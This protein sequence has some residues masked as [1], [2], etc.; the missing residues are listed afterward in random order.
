[1]PS[2]EEEI[3]TYATYPANPGSDLFIQHAIAEIVDQFNVGTSVRIKPKSLHKFG[4]ATGLAQD[5]R[6]TIATFGSGI[7][8]ETYSTTNDIDGIVCEST[9]ADQVVAIEGHSV[10]ASGSLTFVAQEATLDGQSSVELTT[11]LAR[12]TRAYI[13]NAGFGSEPDDADDAIYIYAGHGSVTV[14]SGVPQTAASIKLV[15][16]DGQNQSE[17]AATSFSNVDYGIVTRI[18]GAAQRASAASN[19]DIAFEVRE[20]GGVFRTRFETTVRTAS[21]GLFLIEPRPYFIVKNN[22][23]VRLVA[24]PSANSTNVTGGFD[25]FLALVG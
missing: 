15:I 20:L 13:A 10:N 7:V 14:S 3:L 21:N 12:A 9:D 22:S 25:C 6:S 2:H 5:T 17:K 8:N 19:V 16:V 24:T 11:P 4:R 23:D 18:Y 1:L